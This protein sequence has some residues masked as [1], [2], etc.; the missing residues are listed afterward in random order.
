M[1]KT[2]C[3]IL[4]KYK[5]EEIFAISQNFKYI[6]NKCPLSQRELTDPQKDIISPNTYNKLYSYD[7]LYQNNQLGNL[8]DWCPQEKTLKSICNY[9]NTYFHPKIRI[10]D[11]VSSL[12][13]KRKEE[14]I[15]L[16]EQHRLKWYEGLYYCY[17]LN[18]NG[19]NFNYGIM[20]I[21]HSSD[22]EYK[23]EAIMDL[24]K[25]SFNEFISYEPIKEMSLKEI[26]NRYIKDL[27]SPYFVFSGE[28]S[29]LQDT[30]II[31][32]R[33]EKNAFSRILTIRR[34]DRISTCK[35]YQG[36]IG[37]MLSTIYADKCTKF[38][39][40]GVSATEIKNVESFKKLFK[41][42][43]NSEYVIVSD[44]NEVTNQEWFDSVVQE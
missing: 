44:I 40:I 39:H 16:N 2:R 26:Y 32:L 21:Y 42:N 36:S 19:K 15:S 8:A 38:Q 7:F 14:F 20:N 31:N 41:F 25:Q 4:K 34:F 13:E 18:I 5:P 22:G 23:C 27:R 11:L 37:T 6:V 35:K 30:V 28:V 3:L 17:Y 9:F 29:L 12:L 24:S 43:Q 33:A 1:T 10:Y